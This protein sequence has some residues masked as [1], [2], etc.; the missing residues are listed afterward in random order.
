VILTAP[1]VSTMA[2]RLTGP[3]FVWTVMDATTF[4]LRVGRFASNK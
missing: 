1:P 2:S 4:D 3:F